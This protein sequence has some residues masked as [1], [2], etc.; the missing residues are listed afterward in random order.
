MLTATAQAPNLNPISIWQISLLED[1]MANYS[2]GQKSSGKM[3]Q[4]MH[5]L[6]NKQHNIVYML[7]PQ[8]H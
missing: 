2:T 4:M 8:I 3:I 1:L 6:F 5:I 7:S